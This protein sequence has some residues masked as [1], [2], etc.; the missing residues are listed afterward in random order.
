MKKE[1]MILSKQC[2]KGS[3]GKRGY[4]QKVSDTKVIMYF[5]QD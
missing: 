5:Y 4:G 1:A 2:Q 3:N